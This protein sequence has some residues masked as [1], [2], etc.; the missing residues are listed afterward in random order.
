MQDLMNEME[1]MRKELH[2]SMRMLRKNGETLAHREYDY[3]VCKAQ[4]VLQMKAQGCTIT[5]IQLSIKGQPA[6]AEALLE[7]DKAKTMYEANQE[8]I[9]VVKLELRVVENQIRRE[10]AES[11]TA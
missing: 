6:V 3:Q 1:N 8:H 10:W 2:D 5:E 9:N 11:G 7:R 4:T